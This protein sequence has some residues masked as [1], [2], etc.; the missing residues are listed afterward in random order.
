MEC[1]Q[2]SFY[3]DTRLQLIEDA[4]H[5]SIYH[6]SVYFFEWKVDQNQENS[7]KAFLY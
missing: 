7:P 3:N 5:V 4:A 1:I 6:S 2:L